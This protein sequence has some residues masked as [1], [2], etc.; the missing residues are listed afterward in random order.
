MKFLT[1]CK[2]KIEQVLRQTTLHGICNSEAR[3][4]QFNGNAKQNYIR[5]KFL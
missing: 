3:K 4:N 1:N 5:E 2:N